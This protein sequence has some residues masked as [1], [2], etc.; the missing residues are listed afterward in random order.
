MQ[1]SF[2]PEEFLVEEILPTGEVLE[3]DKP[4]PGTP[5]EGKFTHFVLQKRLWDTPRALLELA[6]VLRVSRKR[7]NCA[8]NK[9]RNAIST[10]RCSAFALKPEDFS[11]A[12]IKDIKILGAWNAAQKV[13]LGELS[14]NRFTISLTE[15]NCGK[16]IDVEQVKARAEENH[17][18]FP[19]F[20]GAQRFGSL[21]QNTHLVGK[22]L[23][24][25]KLK[26]AVWNYLT[27]VDEREKTEGQE[28]RK[29]FEEE[30]DLSKALNYYPLHL[31]FERTLIAHLHA[32]KNDY[33]GAL[34]KFPRS[35]SLLFIHAYQSYLFNEL[36]ATRLKEEELFEAS[37]GDFYCKA[38]KLGFPA[39]EKTEEITSKK[40]A[41]SVN[42]LISKQKAFLVGNV[43]GYESEPTPEEKKLLK[44]EGLEPASFKLAALPELSSKGT[45]RA[46]FA[47]LGDFE[48]LRESP[49][50]VRFSLPSGV[51]ATVALA[52]LFGES[53]NPQD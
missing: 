42:K 33:A 15:A 26:E 18:L 50:Q 25:N 38:D 37:K 40:T 23:V 44:K 35:L 36:L 20:F 5:A 28:A 27:F 29:K 21:R 14:G 19:N 9:D 17:G 53:G 32:Y 46:L 47:P 31:K 34:R 1:F 3:L 24:Q 4:F 43:L 49:L 8:G 48:I 45:K 16:P 6:K 30:K 52:R 13:D 2:A 39:V 10:Q 12:N 51:Y 41:E 7:F 11:R 22:L